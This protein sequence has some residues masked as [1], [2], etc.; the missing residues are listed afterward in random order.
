M[1]GRH[2]PVLN[3]KS[4]ENRAVHRAV[5]GGGF[6]A[7]R[8]RPSST[9]SVRLPPPAVRAR[10]AAV[11]LM[12]RPASGSELTQVTGAVVAAALRRAACSR[13]L[14]VHVCACV[15]DGS[16]TRLFAMRGAPVLIGSG[17]TCGPESGATSATFA[18][19][20]ELRVFYRSGKCCAQSSPSIQVSPA[21]SRASFGTCSSL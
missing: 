21:L 6:R 8:H 1:S 10:P 20:P 19:A 12:P 5:V 13:Y 16:Q 2:R 7:K 4:V 15:C 14:H 9:R 17:A 3:R 18:M 11:R